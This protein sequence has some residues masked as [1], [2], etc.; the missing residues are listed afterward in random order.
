VGCA[1][2]TGGAEG[3]TDAAADGVV[4]NVDAA[5]GVFAAGGLEAD[6]GVALGCAV[7]PQPVTTIARNNRVAR[8]DRLIVVPPGPGTH[9]VGPCYRVS[10]L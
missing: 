5:V 6:E 9:N 3:F 10:P 7:P 8:D 2:T 4:L 1:T